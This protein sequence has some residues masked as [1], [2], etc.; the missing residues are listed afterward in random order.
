[1]N[2]SCHT[3]EWA[4]SHTWMSHVTHINRFWACH[5]YRY[6]AAWQGQQSTAMYCNILQHPAAP[7]NT[8][9]RTATHYNALQHTLQLTHHVFIYVTWLS[10]RNHSSLASS[11]KHC[12][13]L[14]HT[15][16]Y[17]NTL[18]HNIAHARLSHICNMTQHM[19]TQLSDKP[20]KE[21]QHTATYCNT[22]QHAATHCNKRTFHSY[23]RHDST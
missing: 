1:M 22:L 21:L 19:K 8:L 7:C 20:S 18:Q 16:T 2:E 9:Q 17:C 23:M 15:T 6:T 13:I 5:A 11:A 12:N 14:K 3:Y 4:M 10:M